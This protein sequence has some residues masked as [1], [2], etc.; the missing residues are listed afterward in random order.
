MAAI[1]G[2]VSY[3]PKRRQKLSQLGFGTPGVHSPGRCR[4][5]GNMEEQAPN[6]VAMKRPCVQPQNSRCLTRLLQIN[7][8]VFDYNQKT[9]SLSQRY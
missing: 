2:A 5:E 1:I 3:I 8:R 9:T 6:V 7:V 4:V